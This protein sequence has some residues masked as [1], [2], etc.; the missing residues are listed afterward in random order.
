[1]LCKHRRG[2]RRQEGTRGHVQ[3]IVG[4]IAE[5]DLLRCDAQFLRQ[6][7]LQR[8]ARAVRIQRHVVQRI[9]RCHQRARAG[10]ERIFVRCQLDDV[11]LV[12]AE[13]ARELGDRLA[14][15]VWG[16]RA[17]IR[18]RRITTIHHDAAG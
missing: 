15:L 9:L 3:H 18:R 17:R 4:A 12:Q 16:N 7:G 10:A 14:G 6:P 1:M 13:F 2:A 5:N 11:G 8:K